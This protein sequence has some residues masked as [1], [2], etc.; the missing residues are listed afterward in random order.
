MARYQGY[1]AT[2]FSMANE[3]MAEF[4]EALWE[5]DEMLRASRAEVS[6]SQ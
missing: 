6:C 2:S 3:V 5:V 4:V 1:M